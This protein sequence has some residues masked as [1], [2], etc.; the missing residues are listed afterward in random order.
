MKDSYPVGQISDH[1]QV[2]GNEQERGSGLPLDLPYEIHDLSLDRCV[3]SSDA[4]VR[5][6]QAWIHN[7]S[8]RNADSL[9]LASGELSRITLRLITGKADSLKD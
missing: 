4:F 6:N 5:D 7:Q 1:G 9:A 3:K 8:P 2:M